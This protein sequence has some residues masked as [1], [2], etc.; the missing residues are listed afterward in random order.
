MALLLY[1]FLETGL[2]NALTEVIITSDPSVS[3]RA[4]VLLGKIV[5]MMHT[6]LPS[7]VC[8]LSSALPLLLSKATEGNHQALAAISTLQLQH[9]ML[10]NRP[11]ACSQFLDNI[12]QSGELIHTR[13]FKRDINS[14]EIAAAT[15]TS[16]YSTLERSGR[17]RQDSVSSNA[18]GG[19]GTLS[20]LGSN[21]DVFEDS[22][23]L[24]LGTTG[25][26]TRSKLLNLFEIR[27]SERL[28]RES[29]VLFSNDSVWDWDIVITILKLMTKKKMSTKMDDNQCKFIHSL[30]AYFKPSSNRF[31][32]Q[33]LVHHG[34]HVNVT[35]GLIL[36]DWLLQNQEVRNV[37]NRF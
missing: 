21:Y 8:S 34:R 37:I 9:Q 31:S 27:E 26:R 30:V 17:K 20:D 18:S 1:C 33:E 6:H 28:M 4:T 22:M 5:H 24:F 35:A 3:V 11:A 29:N 32:H 2:L 13:I 23:I 15:T 7:E 16:K 19:L 36:I 10:R 14:Q 25:R 12:I